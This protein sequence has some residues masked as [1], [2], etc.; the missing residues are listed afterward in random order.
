M[1]LAKSGAT[2]FKEKAVYQ[3]AFVQMRKN[4]K[5]YGK[6][7]GRIKLLGLSLEEQQE[8]GGFLGKDFA[9]ET[10]QFRMVDFAQALSET[11]FVGLTLEMLLME[12]FGETMI[13]NR[14]VELQKR[15]SQKMFMD[16]LYKVI[17]KRH[18][19]DSRVTH[20]ALEMMAQKKFGYRLLQDEYKM[21]GREKAES[22]VLC[23][24]T[25]LVYL[26]RHANEQIRLAL[27]GAEVMLN[28]HAFDQKMP[29]GKLLLQALGYIHQKTSVKSAEEILML[30]YQ[31]GIKPDDISS[32]TTAY[33]IRLYTEEGEHMAYHA[34]IQKNEPYVIT[35][36]N[37]NHIL[38][39]HCENSIVFLIENQMVFSHICEE[40]GNQNIALLCTS[41][42][43]KTASLIMIDL[44]CAAGHQ[45]YYSGDIDPEGLNIADKVLKRNRQCT[46]WRMS[47]SDYE[48]CISKEKVSEERLKKLNSV[49]D[50]R[51]LAVSAKLKQK[52]QAGYQERLIE[53]LLE[54]IRNSLKGY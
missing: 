7:A 23:I 6:V 22:L 27:L 5:K 8:L 35:L 40:M 21:R 43:M 52:K 48:H 47:V 51:L 49:Q 36:S 39:V 50:S 17:E 15:E 16:S 54:D 1:R 25:A 11:R 45:L 34:F 24:C 18:G 12:Y 29:A 42:Q 13:Q 2:Y 46:P 10:V 33:G 3:K 32:F 31:A 14:V 4:W 28:P 53:Y 19:Q 9:E 38:R 30:Y 37:L 26:E 44:L 20:W 41:G